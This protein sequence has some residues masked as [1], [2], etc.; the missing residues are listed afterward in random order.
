M[1]DIPSVTFTCSSG[2]S[3]TLTVRDECCGARTAAV[4]LSTYRECL[5]LFQDGIDFLTEE[6][7]EWILGENFS[8]SAELAR[9]RRRKRAALSLHTV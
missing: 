3:M 2:E 8:G 1:N 7:K 6:D 5:D 9:S 4:S